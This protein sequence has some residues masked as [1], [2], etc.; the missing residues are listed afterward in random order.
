M[1]PNSVS[2]S[3]SRLLAAGCAIEN[4]L[5]A[6]PVV[7]FSLALVTDIVYWRTAYLEWQN[8]SAWLLFFG[9]V[10]GAVAAIFRIAGF[11]IRPALR[12]RPFFW[13]YAIGNAL[14][15]L[16]AIVNSFVHAGDGWTAVVPNG[17]ILSAL[18]VLLMLATAALGLAR[19]PDVR[20]VRP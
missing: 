14:V 8:F 20:G 2:G 7:C 15:L 19:L 10:V 6:F 11:I 18:T 13:P 9:L 5:V 1:A 16:L 17:L 3:R 12:A 4:V